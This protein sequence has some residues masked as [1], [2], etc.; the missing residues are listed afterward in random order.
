[1]IILKIKLF[2]I[3]GYDNVII[4]NFSKTDSIEK[5]EKSEK[6]KRIFKIKYKMGET[7]KSNKIYFERK[8]KMEE[9]DKKRTR[10]N[11]GK[12]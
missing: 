7:K 8:L 4:K 9:R 1:M 10:T 5:D 6:I 2:E 12:N 11:K 3:E